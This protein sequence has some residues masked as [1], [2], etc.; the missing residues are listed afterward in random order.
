MADH[1][2][3]LTAKVKISPAAGS[4]SLHK[5]PAKPRIFLA[6]EIVEEIASTIKEIKSKVTVI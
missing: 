6:G 4:F 3:T 1:T 2:S 5:N